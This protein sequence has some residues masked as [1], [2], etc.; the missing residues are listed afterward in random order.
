FGSGEAHCPI[1][2]T[3]V[4]PPSPNLSNG[5]KGMS[6]RRSNTLLREG[7]SMAVENSKPIDTRTNPTTEPIV[8]EF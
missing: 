6:E 8:E 7:R 3:N 5:R 1:D 4:A 2:K